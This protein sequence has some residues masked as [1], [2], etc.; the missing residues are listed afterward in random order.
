VRATNQDAFIER[1]DL[2]LWAIADG[3]GGLSEGEMASR[4]VCDSL[5]DGAVAATLDEQ[6]EVAVTQLQR[7]NEH[8]RRAATR[9]VNPVQS[10]STVVVLLIRGKECAVI[11]AGDSRAYRLRD[12]L[13][14]QLTTDHSWAAEGAAGA[15]SNAQSQAITR[16]IG[17]EDEFVPEVV[18][19]EVRVN[20]RFVLLSD[21]VARIL[22]TL[23]LGKI[24]QTA[25]PAACCALLIEQAIAGGGT[26]NVTAIV[27]DCGDPRA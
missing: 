17:T 7:V 19:S 15:P 27:V 13:I 14:S 12:G 25:G 8:L 11:W 24:L 3:M 18:R 9:A 1:P 20:D 21:G 4:M 16:A 23:A 26:D 5:A 22:D 2:K 6:I 10:G